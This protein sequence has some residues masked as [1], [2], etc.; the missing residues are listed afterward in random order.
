M[1]KD[2]QLPPRFGLKNRRGGTQGLVI[3]AILTLALAIIFDLGAIASLGSAVALAVF[4]LITAA[5]LRMI[6]E[7]KASKLVL[8]LALIAT[9]IAILLFLWYTAITDPGLFAILIVTVILAW[10]IEAVL[11]RTRKRTL[12][13]SQS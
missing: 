1:A 10:A 4:A 11:M 13:V 5:H 8:I 3:S 2:G 9:S 6:D 12:A 7:T